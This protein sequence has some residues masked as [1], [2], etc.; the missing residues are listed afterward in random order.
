M[1]KIMEWIGKAFE[2]ATVDIWRVSIEELPKTKSFLVRQVRIIMLAVKGFSEDKIQLRASALTFYSMLSVVPVFALAFGIAKGFG[3]QEKMQTELVQNFQGHQEVLQWIINFANQMLMN[4]KGGFIAGAGV[5]ILLWSVMKV[6][7]NIEEAFNG[8]WQIRKSRTFVRKF[9]DYFSIVLIAPV[10]F[11][12][13]S[14]ATVFITAQL[15][16]YSALHPVLENLRFLVKLSPYFLIW[17]LFILLYIIMPNTKVKFK[18]ALIGGLIAGSIFQLVQWG[19]IHFQIGVSR[20]GTIYGSFAA[21]PLFLIW[22]QLS[23]LIVLLGAEISF[24][25]QNVKQYEFESDS[26]RIS[27]RL[28]RLLTLLVARLI[29]RNFA[30]EKEAYSASG[31][32]DN[33]KIPMRLVRDIIYE[34]VEVKILVE[35]ATDNP[36]ERKYQPALDISQLSINKVL[37][38]LDNRGSHHIAPKHSSGYDELNNILTSFDKLIKD[39]DK[40]ILLKDLK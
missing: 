32:S 28:K 38:L 33:L 5:I 15:E 1:K 13:S 37:T 22:L 19:Y 31:I 7:G 9:S 26:L 10:F 18:S 27:L 40:N 30:E 4:V 3:F 25:N 11:F 8:I 20:Y 24:A 21:L 39:S 16:K 12:L 17:I 23:W 34:L 36:K 35:L 14:S 29:I 6:L 2:F